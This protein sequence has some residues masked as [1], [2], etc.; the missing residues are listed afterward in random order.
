M[1][2]ALT[3]QNGLNFVGN[4]LSDLTNKF[5]VAVL[6]LLIGFVIGKVVGKLSQKLL[7]ELELDK[8]LKNFRIKIPLES[9]ISHALSYFIYFIVIIMSLNQLGLTAPI[10]NLLSL[11]IML[12][13]ILSLLLSIKDFFPNLIAGLILHKKNKLKLND[14]LEALGVKGKIVN[15]TLTETVIKTSR[16]DL[17]Y[18]PNLELN[19]N[20]FTIK[21]N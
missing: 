13:L 17:I 4:L 21:R 2:Q 20:K 18:I 8:N 11:A 10:V 5:V 6:I 14:S 16:G 19:K 9:L 3:L 12:L 15:L 7:H 1:A